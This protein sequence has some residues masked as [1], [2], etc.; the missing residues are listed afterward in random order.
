MASPINGVS[1][2]APSS[3]PV[4]SVADGGSGV[5]GVNGALPPGAAAG[6]TPVVTNGQVQQAVKAANNV[7]TATGSNVQLAY[8]SK[9]QETVIK[10]VDTKSG[11]VLRQYPS[12]EV[13]AIAQA[14]GE[15]QQQMSSRDLT[16]QS[17]GEAVKGILIRQQG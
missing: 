2:Q 15:V 9:A 6:G 3:A 14:L 5:A 1:A 11:E 13:L 8:D 7:F 17:A 10:L 4:N 12:K 16:P